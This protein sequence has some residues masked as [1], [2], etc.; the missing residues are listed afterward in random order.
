MTGEIQRQPSAPSADELARMALD[1]VSAMVAYWDAGLQCRFANAAYE[2]WFGVKPQDLVGKHI[3]EL[4]G[5]LY[6]LNRPYI[7]AA[8]R[9]QPQEF[10]REIP[11]PAGGPA[12]HS[13][14]HYIPDVAD[15]VVRGFF[16]LVSDISGVKRAELALRESEERFRLTLE[17]APR[18]M[19]TVGTDGR[20]L[21][22]NR[23]LC[24][25]LG[26]SAQELVG[27]TF[28][29]VTHPDDLDADLALAGQLARGEMPRYSLEKRYIRKDGRIVDVELSGSVLRDASGQPL[30]FIAQVEDITERKRTAAE[31]HF[32]AELGP[33]LAST[34]DPD[35]I[36][37][38]VARLVTRTMADFCIIDSIDA[39]GYDEQLQRRHVA[40][41]VPDKQWLAEALH[42]VQLDRT[43]PYLLWEAM[44]TGRATQLQQPTDKDLAALAQAPE[45]LCLLQAL[46]IVSMVAVPLIAG[47]R[48][49][50]GIALIASKGSREL[51]DRDARLAQELAWRIAISIENA[52]LYAAARKATKV[53]DEV[54]AIVAHDL[55]NPLSTIAM[56]AELLRR[57]ARQRA[58]V[59]AIAGESI[60]RATVRMARLIEDL[61]DISRMEAGRLSVEQA[62]LDPGP[63]L[64]DCISSQRHL[65]E[66]ASIELRL[67]TPQ[68][69]P[70]L[71]ADR[72]R[73]SQV[74][75]N[76]IGN[77]LKFSR[78]GGCITVGA[79]VRE[80][81]V[82][83][84]V[85]D[86]GA[87]I[88]PE[89]L[90]HLFDRFW[91]ARRAERE[92][93]GLGLPIAKAVVEAHGGRIWVAPASSL[94]FRYLTGDK[95]LQAQAQFKRITSL[96]L[97][98]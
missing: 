1:K 19:A 12:R 45:H 42:H 62:P 61:I 10:E 18:G 60:Q 75:E 59:E 87:G 54:L 95:V 92:G 44:R 5:P 22:V 23:A 48:L 38:S 8:L 2:A 26:Y 15:G 40:S 94:P 93:A 51:D 66:S 3:S 70:Q 69:L 4:L 67:Q 91:Q 9:G 29:A 96:T 7:E 79:E 6:P 43:K 39:I 35:E 34:F 28:Q 49:V 50:G 37:D 64:F 68:K 88:P 32:L 76:L 14:A 73:L 33:V 71:W 21:R 13:L 98:A 25:I 53:R 11:D 58:G 56:Q 72:D 20:F 46:E 30:H 17:D 78:S 81:E 41:R 47:G 90:P 74:F 83:F 57:H 31:Q 52:R 27:M 24:D 97:P 65:A 82:L 80:D 77:A 89:H 36:F 16:V 55:R 84:S 85:R 86:T 63:F